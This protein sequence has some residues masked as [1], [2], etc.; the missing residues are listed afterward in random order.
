[1][2]CIDMREIIQEHNQNF[3]NRQ[4]INY[5]KFSKRKASDEKRGGQPDHRKQRPKIQKLAAKSTVWGH[6]SLES[7]LC[8]ANGNLERNMM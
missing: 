8:L 7:S 5:L 2:M 6:G 1:M 3:I 4:L